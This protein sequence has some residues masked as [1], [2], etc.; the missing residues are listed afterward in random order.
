MKIAIVDVGWKS[1][2]PRN[3]FG[4]ALG[5]S[6]TWLVQI[7]NEFSKNNC[8]VDVYCN[9]PCLEYQASDSLRYINEQ[10]FFELNEKYDF[11]IL[12][13]FF[14]KNNVNY[15]SEISKRKMAN[16]VY[17]QMHDLS[18]IKDVSLLDA[19]HD[20][21][22]F[23][24][25]SDF[26]TIV[27]LNTWHKSNLL[28]QYPKLTNDPICIPNGVDL[29]ML[30]KHKFKKDNRVLWSS[31]S[32]RGLDILINDIYPIVKAEIPDFGID[33]AGYNDNAQPN[34]EDDVVYLGKLSKE[35]LYREQSKH[36]V[37]F[38]PGVFAETFCITMLENVMNGCQIVSPFTFGTY[39]TIGPEVAEKLKMKNNFF[40]DSYSNAVYEAANKIIE[41][42]KSDGK[43]PE[44]YK[45]IKNRIKER[46][47]WTFSVNLYLNHYNDN[48]YGENNEHTLYKT[49]KRKILIL[50]M[51]CNH[52]HFKS[53]LA[54]VKDTWAKP[55]IHEKIDD[56]K[57]FAYTSCDH[58][59]PHPSIDW[60]DHMIYVD[61]PDDIYHTYTKTQK[62]YSMIKNAGIDFDYIVRTNSSVYLNLTNLA[63]RVA[64]MEE[65]DVMGDIVGYYH[66]Y[67]DG[68]REFMWNIVPGMFFGMSRELFEI[69]MSATNNYDYIPTTD[70]V[71]ISGVLNEKLRDKLRIVNPNKYEGQIKRYKP[72][73]EE[74]YERLKV[75]PVPYFKDPSLINQSTII[76]FRTLYGDFPE[77]TEKGHE[78]EHLYELY[79]ADNQ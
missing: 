30:G 17:I 8:S 79:E 71:I 77:R 43:Q 73:F 11:I 2:N 7:A 58:K 53:L 40:G 44:L 41:I 48:K 32:E 66:D 65:N 74:D 6:E 20:L 13:R 69:A 10:R 4:E 12:S 21:S 23:N 54:G 22:K 68:R 27:T 45:D 47:N 55:I 67:S 31:C 46:Y 62:A 78:L 34:T 14:E 3:P 35:E 9:C 75:Q 59:H 64:E 15:I 51:S 36:K 24:L 5:G 49:P 38:Y 72:C 19:N 70:D 39:P 26:V 57:W 16:H 61:E 42:L 52:P 56:I 50:T 29:S 18:F 25:N 33:F 60:D 28:A 63:E 76:Q 1:I 37:W